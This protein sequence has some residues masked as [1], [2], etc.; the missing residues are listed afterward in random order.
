VVSLASFI[1][2]DQSTFFC[3]SPFYIVG[4]DEFECE[5]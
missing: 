1:V 3:L 4:V 5:R 2:P